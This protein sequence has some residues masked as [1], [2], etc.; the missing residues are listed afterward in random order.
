MNNNCIILK[1][2]LHPSICFQHE[3]KAADDEEEASHFQTPEAAWRE[4]IKEQ[5]VNNI[6]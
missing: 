4:S 3:G 5:N 2:I 1:L 6:H